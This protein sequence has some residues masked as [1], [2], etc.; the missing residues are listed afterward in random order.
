MDFFFLLPL[1]VLQFKKL[2]VSSWSWCTASCWTKNN[3]YKKFG[4]EFLNLIH[5]MKCY[6]VS[7]LVFLYTWCFCD[8]NQKLFHSFMYYH[9]RKTNFWG[10][11]MR[12]FYS[13]KYKLFE[14]CTTVENVRCNM[15]GVLW[16][17]GIWMSEEN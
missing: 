16:V 11:V 7:I 3:N 4:Y 1:L 9:N 12:N 2:P 15:Y 14:S 8:S 10:N 17:K 5:M 6:D 13:N